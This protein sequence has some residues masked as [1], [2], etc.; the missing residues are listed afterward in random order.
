M[1][2]KDKV[3]L[4][5]GPEKNA[6]KTFVSC[7]LAVSLAELGKK[8]LIIDADLRNPQIHGVSGSAENCL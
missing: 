5:T 8:V 2:L 7:N 6:G 4:V 3:V 1:T